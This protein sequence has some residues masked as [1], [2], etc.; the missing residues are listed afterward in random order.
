MLY[1]NPEL[2]FQ[3]SDFIKEYS[4]H[5]RNSCN[6]RVSESFV[7]SIWFRMSDSEIENGEFGAFRERL[8]EKFPKCDAVIEHD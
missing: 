7:Y 5:Q 2:S 4:K 3:I 1:C 6:L 8:P